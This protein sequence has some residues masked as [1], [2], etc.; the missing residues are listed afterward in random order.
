MTDA[1]HLAKERMNAWGFRKQNLAN[2]F[3]GEKMETALFLPTSLK[4]G[5]E[6][7]FCLSLR[8]RIQT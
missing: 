2:Q 8:K 4:K 7:H 1:E 3:M 6:A 5:W